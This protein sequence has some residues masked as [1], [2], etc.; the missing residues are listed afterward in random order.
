MPRKKT[1]Q[2]F[3]SSAISIYGNKYDYSTVIYINSSTKVEI[4]CSKHGSFFKT[5]QKFLNAKQECPECNGR[6][7]WT[8]DKFV[9]EANKFHNSKCQYPRHKFKTTKTK[10]I[11]ICPVHGEF[12]QSIFHHLR[13]DVINV[14]YPLNILIKFFRF[15]N[16][17]I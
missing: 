14:Q 2:D 15:V 1:L 11:I 12:K 16:E 3:I 13:G 7:N 10:Y 9:K 4:L 5:P 17:S 8:W 6:I